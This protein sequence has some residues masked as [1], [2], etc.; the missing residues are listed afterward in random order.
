[1]E[2]LPRCAAATFKSRNAR[3]CDGNYRSMQVYFM[4]YDEFEIEI[5]MNDQPSNF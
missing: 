5:Q 3:V 4:N 1:M 2:F